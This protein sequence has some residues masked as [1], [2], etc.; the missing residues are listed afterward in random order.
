MLHDHRRTDKNESGRGA[1]TYRSTHH[2]QSRRSGY[3]R[4]DHAVQQDPSQYRSY[5][6]GLGFGTNTRTDVWVTYVWRFICDPWLR[7]SR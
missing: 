2:A 4:L 3:R 1:L 5:C 6:F 7:G